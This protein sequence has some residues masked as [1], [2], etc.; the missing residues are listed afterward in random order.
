M[1]SVDNHFTYDSFTHSQCLH[2]L[3]IDAGLLSTD[4]FILQQPQRHT[5]CTHGYTPNHIWGQVTPTLPNDTDIENKKN[6]SVITYCFENCT[7]PVDQLGCRI[8]VHNNINLFKSDHWIQLNLNPVH[9]C[10]YG[11]CLMHLCIKNDYLHYHSQIIGLTLCLRILNFLSIM[12][13][14]IA[15]IQLSLEK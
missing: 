13:H 2:R 3:F 6:S 4:I 8:V 10:L 15:V 12:R 14:W 9:E 1:Y 5:C 7:N 11:S